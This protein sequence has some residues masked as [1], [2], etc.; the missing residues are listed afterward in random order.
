MDI[1]NANDIYI[2]RTYAY[3]AAGPKG[4][5]IVDVEAPERPKLD[6]MFDADGKMNDTRAV[7]VCMTN[8]SMFAYIADG[9]N[10]MKV[11]QL[12]SPDDTPK[13]LGFSPR[14]ATHD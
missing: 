9:K 8:A 2:S 6:Q 1:A 11:V 7:K 10:G 3:V 14:P 5:A 4:L 12:T 13:Y